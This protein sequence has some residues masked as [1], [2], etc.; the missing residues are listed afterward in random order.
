[1]GAL[2]TVVIFP[3]AIVVAL[4]VALDVDVLARVEV[5]AV[6]VVITVLV[7][8]MLL[9]LVGVLLVV[10]VLVPPAGDFGSWS[11]RGGQQYTFVPIQ[12]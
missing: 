2:G 4:D 12:Q 8:V 5:V 11:G 9:V 3:P 10:L 6:V 1:M 7:C